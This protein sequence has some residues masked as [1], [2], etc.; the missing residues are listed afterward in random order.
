[1][2]SNYILFHIYLILV[3]TSVSNSILALV[4]GNSEI[5]PAMVILFFMSLIGLACNYAGWLR[6][7]SG[8]YRIVLSG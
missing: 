8:I 5:I 2:S 6:D 3:I 4:R 7:F 1:M